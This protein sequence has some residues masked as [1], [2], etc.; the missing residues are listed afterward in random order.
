MTSS[1]ADELRAIDADFTRISSAGPEYPSLLSAPVNV[2]P[3]YHYPTRQEAESWQRNTPFYLHEEH[4]QYMTYVYR[5]PGESCFVVRSHIDEE[6]D[7]LAAL[8]Q[9]KNQSNGVLTAATSRSGTPVGNK[10]KISWSAYKN[11]FAGGKGEAKDPSPEKE[12]P[13]EM[14]ESQE[15]EKANGV[16]S[17]TKGEDEV[18]K[19]VSP[20]GGLKRYGSADIS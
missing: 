20:T 19:E 2:E 4:L 5:E 18:K 3:R 7:R 11:K 1:D 6:R 15:A 10:K 14:E 9:S 17:E 13:I 12:Q 16:E 8:Q